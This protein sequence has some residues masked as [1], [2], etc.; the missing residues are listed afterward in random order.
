[1]KLA[2]VERNGCRRIGVVLEES[3]TLL[4]LATAHQA[5]TGAVSPHFVDMLALIDG[6]AAALALARTYLA[7]P[8]ATALFP[9]SAVRWLAPLPEPRQ[10]RDC[11]VFEEHLKNAFAQAEQLTGRS[12][13][14]PPVW[15]ERPLYYK[16]NRFSVIGTD[17]EVR[18]PA[19]S[20]VMDFELELACIIGRTGVD[21]PRAAAADYIFGFTIFNDCSARDTQFQEMAGQLGPAK[22]KDFDTGNVFGPWIVTADEIGDPY[23]LQMTARVNGEV[24]GG[25]SS[26]AMYHRFE[27]IIAFLSQSETLHAGEIIGS[28]TV[29]TGCGLELGRYL[30]PGD[31]VELEIERIGILR[32]RFVR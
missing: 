29:G 21:I 1:M 32:N 12:Y 3:A 8:P 20:Q 24:W 2:T 5:V 23:Q 22:G 19:Y 14:I 16:A 25:G 30:Q 6:G 31:V 15:Y 17:Q 10:I 7:A 18:W 28:G 9:L 13:A 4:D 26:G 27:D 11:L